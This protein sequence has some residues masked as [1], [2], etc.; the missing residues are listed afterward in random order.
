MVERAA[1]AEIPVLAGISGVV[2]DHRSPKVV[3]VVAGSKYKRQVCTICTMKGSRGL[4]ARECR[5]TR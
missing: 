1:E 4:A 3:G 2:I 5:L